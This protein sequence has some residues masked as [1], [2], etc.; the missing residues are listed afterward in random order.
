MPGT[1]AKTYVLS[2]PFEGNLLTG[3]RES[4]DWLQS[5][6]RAQPDL[7]LG[8]P[9][10]RWIDAAREE[11]ERFDAEDMPKTPVLTLLGSEENLIDASAVRRQMERFENG[12]LVEIPKSRHEIWMERAVLQKLA[13]Q[14]VDAFLTEQGAQ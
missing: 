6:A 13:W 2:D 3:D 9:T 5:H 8:G 11:F 14:A 4:W 1:K 10:L 7:V 12:R